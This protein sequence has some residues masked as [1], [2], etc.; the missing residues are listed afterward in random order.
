[1]EK[2]EGPKRKTLLQ[3]QSETT[4]RDPATHSKNQIIELDKLNLFQC[5]NFHNLVEWSIF[6]HTF[7]TQ[8]TMGQSNFG[9]LYTLNDVSQVDS[10]RSVIELDTTATWV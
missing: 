1:M 6:H 3:L 7:F 10:W 9:Q 5:K 2:K 4:V 8:L